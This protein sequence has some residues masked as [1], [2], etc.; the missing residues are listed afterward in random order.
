M[1]TFTPVSEIPDRSCRH[2][3]TKWIKLIEA[4]LA[5]GEKCAHVEVQLPDTKQRAY[6]GLIMAKRRAFPNDIKVFF[7]KGEVYLERL[8][9]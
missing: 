4:F 3:N 1:T 9:K 2:I 8:K 7:R 6:N 5:S